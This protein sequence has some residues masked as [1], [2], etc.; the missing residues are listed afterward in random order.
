MQNLQIDPQRLWDMLMETAR[1][2]GTAKGGICRL[3]LTDLD[4]QVRDWFKAQCEALGCAVTV[5]EVGNMFAL[6]PGRCSDVA[7]IAIGSHLDTQPTGGKFDGALGVLGGLEVLKTLHELG[8]ETNA[9]LLLVNWTNEEGSRFAPA[10][11]GSGAFTGVF[12]RAY[13]DARAD[14]QGVTFADAIEAIGYRGA[15][16]AGAVPMGAMFELH[17]EQ[18]PIL[19][20]ESKVIGIVKGV[21]GMRWYEA[22]FT[23]QEAHTGSTP[24]QLRRNAL[25][26]AARLVEAVDRIAKAKPLAVGTVGLMEVKPNSRNVIPGEVFLT[27][28][29]RHP[30][31]AVLDAMEG[32]L[33]KAVAAIKSETGLDVAWRRIWESPPV[34]FDPDCIACVREGAEKAGLP[35]REIISGAGH[36]AA[37]VARVKPTTMI[38][39]PCENGISHNEAESTT[40]EEC[41][42]GAQVLLNAVLAYDRRFAPA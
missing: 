34:A 13:A 10:M 17:I 23:G 8:Y 40:R 15:T 5:D 39:V 28:D 1:I 27:I 19:E 21:Q 36:D 4:R 18:G 38:F 32:D 29:F 30:L 12:D 14:R 9:P 26:G 31:D 11:L 24:M 42:A 35:A 3:T 37:Y 7:P 33:G 2:G 20:A 16:K 6:R 41:A 22:T 25:L